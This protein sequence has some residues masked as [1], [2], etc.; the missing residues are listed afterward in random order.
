VDKIRLEEKQRYQ[1]DLDKHRK[2]LEADHQQRV[3]LYLDREANSAKRLMEQDK[4]FQ[5]RLYEQRQQLQLQMEQSNHRESALSRKAELELQGLRTFEL[6]LKETTL[7]LEQREQ[8]IKNQEYLLQK[9]KTECLEVA[10]QE[11]RSQ[12]QA[13]LEENMIQRKV[14]LTQQ[15]KIDQEKLLI[16]SYQSKINQ[17]TQQLH[18]LKSALDTK[19]MEMSALQKTDDFLRSQLKTEELHITQVNART[20]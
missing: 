13:E 20:R 1:S 10:R 8:Q 3:K 9:Q 16:H 19:E 7:Y 15:Q 5:Q 14:L 6:R 17:L 11:I 18:E 12:L 4:I 2:E